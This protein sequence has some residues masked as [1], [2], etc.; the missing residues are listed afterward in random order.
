MKNF[1]K[2]FIFLILIA[3]NS[4]SNDDKAIEIFEKTLGEDGVK[5]FNKLIPIVENQL[6]QSYGVDTPNSAYKEFLKDVAIKDICGGINLKIPQTELE[7]L[8][9]L[10]EKNTFRREIWILTKEDSKVLL[11]FNIEGKYLN[12]FKKASGYNEIAFNY[13]DLRNVTGEINYGLVANALLKNDRDLDN[14]FIKRIVISDFIYMNL[15]CTNNY[16]LTIY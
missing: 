11:D 13:Y 2:L 14:Y 12:A 15:I 10:F 4:Q 1:I 9:M 16:D 6:M 3:C 8:L 5:V 7:N